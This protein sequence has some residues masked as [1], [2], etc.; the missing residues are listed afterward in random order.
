MGYAQQPAPGGNPYGPYPPYGPPPKRRN[1]GLI[2][3]LCIVLGVLLLGGG[4]VGVIAY[5]NR[6]TPDTTAALT[7]TAPTPAPS[8]TQQ[9]ATPSDSPT[10]DPDPSSDPGPTSTTAPPSSAESPLRHDE[11]KDWNFQLGTV[12][13]AAQKVAGWTYDNC[14]PVD[15]EGVLAKYKC[16]SAVQLAY[17]AYGGHLKAVQL[18]MAFPSTADAKSASNRLQKLTSDAVKWRTDKTHK[19]YTY[20]KILSGSALK[21]VLVTIVTAD[22]SAAKAKASQFQAYL[23]TDHAKYFI[24]RGEALTS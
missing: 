12:K 18:I 8:G 21:Y 6:S 19:K 14:D 24:M 15:G 16:E 20:G 23:Q 17:S 10:S 9:P 11:F 22:S 1:T 3:T 5:L 4:T 7:T 13:F 2:I